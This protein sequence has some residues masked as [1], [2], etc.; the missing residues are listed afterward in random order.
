MYNR[1]SS[2]LKS[3][4][5]GKN[6][7]KKGGATD[8]L[9]NEILDLLGKNPKFGMNYKQIARSLGV[10]KNSRGMQVRNAL[11]RL[12]GKGQVSES[13]RGSF[14]INPGG[15]GTGGTITG[16]I[17][18]TRQGY[19]FL[20]S[21][22][23]GDDIFL[24]ARSLRTALHG[25]KVKVRLLVTRKGTRPEGEVVEI[26]ERARDS[27]VGTIEVMPAFAFLVPDTKNMPFDLFVP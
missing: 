18:M 10:D 5:Q 19:A 4:T 25:D 20:V 7:K 22:E 6:K 15:G 17:D 16:T 26:L 23:R 9:E 1:Q 27:F 8:R 24:S 3:M 21:E 13:R 14:R 12:K 11:T 2:D